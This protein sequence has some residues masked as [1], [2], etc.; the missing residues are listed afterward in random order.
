M[1]ETLQLHSNN[2]NMM[3]VCR[4]ED[5]YCSFWELSFV[6]FLPP[7]SQTKKLSAARHNC[8]P[9]RND[10]SSHFNEFTKTN[11]CLQYV[12]VAKP[13]GGRHIY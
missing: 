2:G 8:P 5:H 13:F 9:K 1:G 11:M 12:H 3:N 6:Y 7:R 10:S 4:G